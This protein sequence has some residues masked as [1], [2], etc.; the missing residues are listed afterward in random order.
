ML[1][2][3]HELIQDSLALCKN[4]GV[5]KMVF[6]T[7]QHL[8]FDH[9]DANEWDYKKRTSLKHF[10]DGYCYT[11]LN[12]LPQFHKATCVIRWDPE[13]L[14]K[15]D[16][17][18]LFEVGFQD[19]LTWQSFVETMTKYFPGIN[20]E[21]IS[22]KNVRLFVDLTLSFDYIRSNLLIKGKSIGHR[23]NR[24]G[25]SISIKSGSARIRIFNCSKWPHR[26]PTRIEILY[27]GAHCPIKKFAEVYALLDLDPFEN[28][29][30][31]GFDPAPDSHC[32]REGYLSYIHKYNLR[33]FLAVGSQPSEQDIIEYLGGTVTSPSSEKS[34]LN[35]NNGLCNPTENIYA[36]NES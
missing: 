4:C 16:E 13:Q 33:R 34:L 11:F 36:K 7:P 29:H 14:I 15:G 35:H 20:L 17:Y 5:L 32:L 26:H 31:I 3:K 24:S 21:D 23:A 12:S 18:A 8:G 28:F 27:S 6:T 1:I 25:N 2:T 10:R 19:Y 9:L 30:L 22:I